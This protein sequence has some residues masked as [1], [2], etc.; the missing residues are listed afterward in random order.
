MRPFP[1]SLLAQAR[2]SDGLL[3]AT[4]LSN[5][6]VVGRYRSAA[7]DA[8]QL[9]R[10]HRGVF[11]LTSHAESFEQ[12]CLAA[13]L[14]APDAALSGATA[15]RLWGLRGV[16]TDDVHLLARRKID[17]DGVETHRTDL[18]GEGDVQLRN[19]LR[20]LRPIRLVCDLAWTIGD[21]ALESVIEQM[22]DRRLFSMSSLRAA[23]RRFSAPGRSGSVRLGRVVESRPSWLKP[24]DSDLELRVHRALANF[25]LN[26]E[27]QYPVLLDS[28]VQVHI[29]LAQPQARFGIEIDHVTWHGGRLDTQSDKRRDR[30]LARLGWTIARV[31]D[32]DISQ[33]LD[34]SIRELVDITARCRSGT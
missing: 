13:C 3:T 34:E 7:L 12:R 29:D 27:R 16:S 10:I 20:V 17:L 26:F 21:D 4:Q 2:S 28:G 8:G 9:V 5:T 33:R 19:G 1:R 24:A 15:G 11:R 23:A 18:L 6:G 14:A 32:D 22:L 31:T 30:G 25:G